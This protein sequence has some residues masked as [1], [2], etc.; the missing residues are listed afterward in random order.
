MTRPMAVMRGGVGEDAA[1][2][3]DGGAPSARRTPISRV[4]R[5]TAYDSTP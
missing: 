1:L 5:L 4:R 3:A 2:D